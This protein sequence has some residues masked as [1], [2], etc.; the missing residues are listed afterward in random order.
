M[1]RRDCRGLRL[2]IGLRTKGSLMRKAGLLFTVLLLTVVGTARGQ[3]VPNP[4]PEKNPHA[5]EDA[6]KQYPSARMCGKCHPSQF[7]EWS[8]SSHAYA[9]VSPM[10]NKFEQAIN[11]FASGTVNYF[12]VRCHAS[13]GTSLGELRSIAWWDRAPAAK[14]GITCVTCHRVGEAYGKSNGARRITPGSIHEAVFGPFDTMGGIKAISGARQYGILVD[15]EEPDRPPDPD[16]KQWIRIHQTAIQSDVLKQAEFCVPCHQVAVYAGIKLETVWE[17]YRASPAAKK[18]ITCQQCH[19][20]KYPGQNDGFRTG[21]AAHVNGYT[22]RNDRP[23]T[24]HTFVGPGYPIS[25][26]GLFPFGLEE[27]PFDPQRWL[28]F[29]YRAKWGSDDF[30]SSAAAR[31]TTFPPEWQNAADRKQAWQIVL[32]NYARWNDRKELRK[33]LMDKAARLEGPF[34]E[35]RAAPGQ[36]LEFS[37]KITNLNEGHNLPS[38]SLGAQ[39]ELWLNVALIDPDGERVWES[40]YMDD[41]GDVADFQARG[42]QEGKTRLDHQ[43]FNMQAKFITTNVKGTDREMYLPVQFD[44]DQRP[45]I[46]PG[47]APNSVLNH[48]PFVRM[49]KRSIPPLATRVAKYHV[50]GEKLKKPGTYKLA[51]R[52]RGRT[53]PIYFMNFVGATNDMLRSENEWADDTHASATEFELGSGTPA[54]RLLGELDHLEAPPNGWFGPQPTI[55]D[56][57]YDAQAQLDIYG[58]KFMNKGSP[59][60]PVELGIRIYDRGAYEPPPTLMGKKNPMKPA[61]MAF[62]DLRI[63]AAYNDGLA[64]KNGKTDQSQLAVRLNMDAELQLTATER[65]HAVLTPF[66]KAAKGEFTSYLISGQVDDEFEDAFNL[67]LNALFFEGDVGAIAQGVTGR[68]NKLDL[69]F[70]FGRVPIFTQNGI[71]TNDAIDGAAVSITAKHNSALDISNYDFT[72][73]VGLDNVTTAAL[74]P[75][76]DGKVF[77]VATFADFLRGYFEAGYAYLDADP[78][79]LSYHNVTAAFSRRYRGKVSNSVRVIGNFGQDASVKTADGWL[80]L[81]ENSLITRKPQELIPYV[82][83][84]AGFDSPQALM[85]AAGTGGV[86]LNTGINFETDGMTNFPTLNANA[87][88]SWGGAVGVEYLFGLDRQIIVEAAVVRAMEDATVSQ[89]AIGIRY[90]HPI[91]NWTAWIFRAD[92]MHGWQ[93]KGDDLTGIRIELRRKF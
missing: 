65:F 75:G 44:V 73:F 10:F 82:N 61:F 36:D 5:W 52:I 58:K 3:R 6:N 40:G 27:S 18:G 8:V 14:E 20:S 69:P 72:F 77:G 76:D 26:P 80:L 11:N 51:V 35:G 37:Y 81:I 64:A 56:G 24:D 53:E 43:L 33:K 39:P 32:E 15:P 29:D 55:Y 74:K 79:D 90:Q 62:G 45:I 28:K 21:A 31:S 85:R 34:F 70:T 9:S 46:R 86:L 93:E 83:L 71:W 87:Q 60:P 88:D 19:M 17:E 66:T 1:I 48:P 68:I 78:S 4:P 92:V 16:G 57:P 22:M 91:K 42:V 7:K 23:L 84:F 63:A 12:C 2:T 38:G 49:E 59:K 67:D 25:H 41:Y 47:G 13:V 30:E 50:P 89:H 54:P